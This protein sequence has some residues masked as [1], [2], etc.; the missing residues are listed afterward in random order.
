M[1]ESLIKIT[2]FKTASKSTSGNYTL[3]VW[4][5]KIVKLLFISQEARALFSSIFSQNFRQGSNVGSKMLDAIVIAQSNYRQTFRQKFN[6]L[7]IENYSSNSCFINW[8]SVSNSYANL[9]YFLNLSAFRSLGKSFWTKTMRLFCCLKKRSKMKLLQ[10][11]HY[12]AYNIRPVCTPILPVPVGSVT[13]H[14][15]CLVKISTFVIKL[16]N[17][18]AR[19][20]FFFIRQLWTF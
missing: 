3:K 9:L 8:S 16:S 7:S 5:H 6:S 12:Q 18:C 2:F 10:K 11:V 20:G 19:Y 13:S 4:I 15:H 1:Y 14:F 17:I